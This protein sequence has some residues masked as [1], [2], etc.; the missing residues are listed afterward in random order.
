MRGQDWAFGFDPVDL[1]ETGAILK[2]ARGAV[3]RASAEVL[4]P[5]DML[6]DQREPTYELSA[7]GLLFGT[8]K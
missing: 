2:S 3:K 6:K 5:L 4:W 8:K 1:Y 7:A